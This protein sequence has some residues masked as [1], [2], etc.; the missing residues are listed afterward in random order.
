MQQ[1][2]QKELS[3]RTA[4]VAS[5]RQSGRVLMDR[6][7]VANSDDTFVQA[8]LID[9]TTKWDRVCQL[10]VSRQDRLQAARQQVNL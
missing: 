10:S 5:I 2:L 8:R 9:L 6:S 1:V 3:K 7:T 4:N